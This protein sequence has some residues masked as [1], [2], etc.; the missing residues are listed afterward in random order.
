MGTFTVQLQEFRDKVAAKG[1]ELVGNVVVEMARRLDLRSPVGNPSL[2]KNPAPKGYVGGRFRG[3]WQLGVGGIPS[4]ETGRIDPA[5]EVTIGAIV[6][7]IPEHPAGQV[8]YLANNVPYAEEIEKGHSTQAPS[9]LLNL[10]AMEGPSIA[11]QA[12]E[13]LK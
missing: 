10:T 13:A 2:W 9:G 5:G 7:E 12:A 1:D 11:R 8:F 6:G 4:G 3:N